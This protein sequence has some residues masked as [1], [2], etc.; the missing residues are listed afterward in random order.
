MTAKEYLNQIKHYDIRIRKITEEIARLEDIANRT[1]STIVANK[2]QTS[3]D[4]SK[5][6]RAID[7]IIDLKEKRTEMMIKSEELRIE[8]MSKIHKLEN[9]KY[10][11][12]LY[13]RYIEGMFINDIAKIMVKS[14][15]SEYNT[16]HIF[17]LHGKALKAFEE[18]YCV[19][20]LPTEQ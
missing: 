9:D 10:I 3:F 19:D 8:V 11:E 18:I 20:D 17:R 4:K 14:D 16:D 5:R 2:V 7:S 6:E 15:G 13:L 12:I 1:T